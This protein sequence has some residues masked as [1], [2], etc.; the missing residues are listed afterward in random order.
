MRKDKAYL[1]LVNLINSRIGPKHMMY[2]Q[3][4]FDDYKN[5]RVMVVTSGVARSPVFLK[6]GGVER[7]YLGTGAST[8][9]L[10]ASQTHE[11]VGKRFGAGA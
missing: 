10:T 11:Y 8:T 9:E 7:F 1:H 4:R 3:V 5:S 2:L 6:D